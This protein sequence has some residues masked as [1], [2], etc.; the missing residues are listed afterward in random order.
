MTKAEALKVADGS[1][2]KLADLLGISHNAV[3]QWDDEK[4]PR[5]REYEI[6]EILE[7]QSQQ[8]EPA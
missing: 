8:P 2:T 5:L 6:K 3:S 4:I 7:Q 1:V